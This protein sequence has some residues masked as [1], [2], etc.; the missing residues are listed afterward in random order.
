MRTD[1]TR[2]IKNKITKETRY[3]ISSLRNATSDKALDFIRQ[4]WAIENSLHWILDM[5]FN[6]DYSR[7][8]KENAPHIMAIIKHVA[9]N[10][11]QSYKSK[12]Q[13]IKELRKIC[14]WDDETMTNLISKKRL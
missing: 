14:S 13:S 2:E 11:L 9:L 10:L 5:S 1:S 4:H 8:R 6:D 12:R 3:Y 7:I